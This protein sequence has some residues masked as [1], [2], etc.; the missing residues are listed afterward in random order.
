MATFDSLD[1]TTEKF[2]EGEGEETILKCQGNHM[3]P[4]SQPTILL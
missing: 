4:Q 3:L 1:M 2:H